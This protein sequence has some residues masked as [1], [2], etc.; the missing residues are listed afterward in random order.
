MSLYEISKKSVSNVLSVAALV[1]TSICSTNVMAE[2]TKFTFI[3]NWYAQ[4]EHGG[5]YQALAEG[6]YKEAGL[7]MTIRM[8]GPQVNNLQLLAAGKAQCAIVDDIGV[9]MAQ[10]RGIPVKMVATSFQFDP[11]VVIT[12]SDIDK[13]ED[14]KGHTVLIASSSQSSWWPW[15]KKKY[16]FTDAMSRPYTF[17]IQPFMLDKTVAQ[18]GY[19]TSEPYAMQEAGA[20]FKSFLI[21][22]EGYPPYGNSIACRTEVI[23]QHPEEI[24]AFI[25]ASMKG[26]KSYLASPAKGNELI[27][28]D[29]PNMTEDRIAY[30]VNLLNSSGIATG[31]DAQTKGIGYISDSRMEKTW[32]MAVE[33]NLFS[34]SEVTLSDVY[35]TEFVDA[36]RVMP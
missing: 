34:A 10:K 30:A 26:W 25:H 21:G 6:F 35:T 16:G 27:I 18:Q 2:P 5:Y 3:T 14:L 8:G 20:D 31:G 23:E 4:A 33:N 15:A 9:M 12:H 29:N 13:L 1:S 17:N 36:V 7:D 28:K 32:D 24:K 19:M 11:T 22:K